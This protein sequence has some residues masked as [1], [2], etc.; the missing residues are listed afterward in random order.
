MKNKIAISIALGFMLGL[1]AIPARAEMRA[2]EPR[3]LTTDARDDYVPA[4]SPDGESVA[5]RSERDGGGIYVIS[6]EG[7]PERRIAPHGR[8]PRFSPDSRWIM[9]WVGSVGGDFLTHRRIYVV[10]TTGGRPRQLV[11]ETRSATRPVWSPDG[12]SIVFW[13]RANQ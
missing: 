4:F 6:P 1:S 5:F 13:A 3:R 11:P 8:R 12:D 2:A 9:Y 10:S 7:G